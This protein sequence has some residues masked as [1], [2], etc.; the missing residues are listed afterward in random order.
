MR[1]DDF[2]WNEAG[3]RREGRDRMGPKAIMGRADRT[4][5]TPCARRNAGRAATAGSAPRPE[6]MTCRDGWPRPPCPGQ[7][8]VATAAGVATVVALGGATFAP[9]AD[10]QVTRSLPAPSAGHDG[11]G[12]LLVDEA[13]AGGG[14][15][16]VLSLLDLDQGERDERELL[17]RLMALAQLIVTAIV[18][19]Q[20]PMHADGPNGS[21]VPDD[22]LVEALGQ[23]RALAEA[24]AAGAGASAGTGTGD[25]SGAA[26][27][28]LTPSR[29]S[30][31]CRRRRPGP[32]GTRP[33]IRWR[34]RPRTPSDNPPEDQ[35][36]EA[37]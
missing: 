36:A 15:D 28:G 22:Q 37:P 29:R 3:G 32:G 25:G 2:T 4:T 14:D 35:A 24:L 21:G 31:R 16:D 27:A 13:P 18:D 1:P 5:T 10:A 20:F 6:P 7:D 26:R 33:T 11:A 8:G 23:L 34:T 30:G 9:L 19:G 12:S 17:R